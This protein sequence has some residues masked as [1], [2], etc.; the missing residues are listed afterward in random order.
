ML[1]QITFYKFECGVEGFQQREDGLYEK[2]R[3][4]LV[5]IEAGSMTRGDIRKAI[6]ESGHECPRGTDV[7]A[8]KVGRVQYKFT[9]EDLMSIAKSR[10]ELTL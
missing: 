8:A 5:T 6:I 3:T 2:R 4:P 1:R 9:T 7:Y 10:E